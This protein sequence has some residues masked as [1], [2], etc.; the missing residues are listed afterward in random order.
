MLPAIRIGDM[1]RRRS[2]AR[3]ALAEV[4]GSIG[5]PVAAGMQVVGRAMALW[6]G[7]LVHQGVLLGEAQLVV[8]R[9]PER[10]Q[11]L[12]RPVSTRTR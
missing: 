1:R 12:G 8:R 7:T 11:C 3:E 5:A 4:V 10:W 9:K 6:A 2:V